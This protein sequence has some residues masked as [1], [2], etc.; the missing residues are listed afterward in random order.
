[1]AE[2]LLE[3]LSEE[4]PARM[5]ARAAE[6]LKRLVC[7]GLK[8]AGLSFERAESYV[9]P[10][11][12]ALVV[13]GLPPATEDSTE[14]RKGPQMGA[15]EKAIQGFLKSAGLSSVDQCEIREVKGKRV[16]FSVTE[17]KGR[18][19]KDVLPFLLVNDAIMKLQWPKSMKSGVDSFVWVRPFHHIL[20][21]FGGE[22]LLDGQGGLAHGIEGKSPGYF[23]PDG[24]VRTD[25]WHREEQISCFSNTTLG[26][27]FLSPKP[28]KV[29]DFA[30]YKAKLLKAKV[31][32]DPAER[33]NLIET[34][35]KK[36]AK[37]QGLTLRPDERLLAEVAGLTEWPVVLM[38]EIDKAF[39]GL[40][41]D[42][43]VTV[44]RHHQ[45]YFALEDSKGSLAPRFIMVADTETRDKGKAIIT[46][47]ERVLKARLADAKYFWD[48]D[49]KRTLESRVP[50]LEGLVFHSELGTMKEKSER[51]ATLAAEIA[52]FVPGADVGKSA[53]CSTPRQSRPSDPHG[54]RVPRVARQNGWSLLRL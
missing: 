10:R 47:N 28:F 4:I 8:E 43:L 21:I 54:G 46:G 32:L 37:K 42:V 12:L 35:A 31:M 48:T 34:Q 3:L 13:D 23:P 45:K 36:L 7:D 40:W 27:R 18:A 26:H 50:D 39:T 29:K 30:D 41:S 16:Y 1:M 2:L 44:M 6:D 15:P 53:H 5:Q 11:R 38:G 24:P 9:T 14:E 25:A 19:T 17:K 20:A 51:I 52:T 22:T 33:R 49:C